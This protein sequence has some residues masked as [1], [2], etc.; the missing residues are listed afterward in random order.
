MRKLARNLYHVTFKAVSRL[1][2]DDSKYDGIVR[3]FS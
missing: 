1:F 3:K 2:T